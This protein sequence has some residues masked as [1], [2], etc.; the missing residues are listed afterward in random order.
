MSYSVFR[1]L[2]R[3]VVL[4]VLTFTFLMVAT[5]CNS[6]SEE[7]PTGPN[8]PTEPLSYETVEQ[9]QVESSALS[10]EAKG[11]FE[12]GMERVI[13]DQSAFQSFWQ[14]LHGENA[15]APNIDFSQKLVVVAML[16]ERPNDGYEAEIASV[17]RD[18][19]P[20]LMSFFVTEIKPGPNCSVSGSS[21]IPYHIIEMDRFSTDQV[22]F[23]DNGTETKD[24][25]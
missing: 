23:P 19:N 22:S 16:G 18:T 6:S 10:E 7:G 9:S 12:D 11:R 5:G 1:S 2:T 13:R 25:E 14:D 4:P 8:A 17:T 3:R 24:C 20:T 21:A 15:E